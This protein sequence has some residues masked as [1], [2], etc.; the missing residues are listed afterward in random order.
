MVI[1]RVTPGLDS[2]LCSQMRT[3]TGERKT[4]SSVSWTLPAW[5]LTLYSTFLTAVKSAHQEYV[6]AQTTLN[7]ESR[8]VWLRQRRETIPHAA[9][10]LELLI[11][12]HLRTLTHH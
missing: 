4:S 12:E 1:I 2:H 5:I 11:H 3:N 9:E 6:V 7:E 8:L 10:K